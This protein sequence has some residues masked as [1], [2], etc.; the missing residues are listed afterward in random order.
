MDQETDTQLYDHIISK[1][2]DNPRIDKKALL[3]RFI[4]KIEMDT[5]SQHQRLNE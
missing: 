2:I 4:S 3:E 5:N 1:L